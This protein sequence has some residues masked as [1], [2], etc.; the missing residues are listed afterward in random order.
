ML[1]T[2]EFPGRDGKSQSLA[3]V[4]PEAD[5]VVSCGQGNI[6][7]RPPMEK[8]IRTLDYVKHDRGF[9]GSMKPDGSIEQNCRYHRIHHCQRIQSSDGAHVLRKGRNNV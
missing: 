4:V 2:D 5:A 6:I 7:I 9:E 1:I 8:V 3:D